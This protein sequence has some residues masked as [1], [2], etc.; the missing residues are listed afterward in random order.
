LDELSSPG[1]RS[2]WLFKSEKS[3]LTIGR[4]RHDLFSAKS[5]STNHAKLKFKDQSIVLSDLGSTNGT[6]LNSHPDRLVK[7]KQYT[8]RDG[9]AIK[10]GTDLRVQVKLLY[11]D[12]TFLSPEDS[13]RLV[14]DGRPS[15]QASSRNRSERSVTPNVVISESGVSRSAVHIRRHWQTSLT[16]VPA[17]Q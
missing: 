2:L 11:S 14:A 5:I 12:T 4:G 3:S 13:H 6:F 15:S 16:K 10:F 9:D 8:L 1:Y 17:Q 7:D